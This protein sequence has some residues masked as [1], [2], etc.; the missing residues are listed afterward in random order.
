MSP[1]QIPEIHGDTQE[2]EEEPATD[3]LKNTQTCEG[4]PLKIYTIKKH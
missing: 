2:E 3:Q 1:S 4:N